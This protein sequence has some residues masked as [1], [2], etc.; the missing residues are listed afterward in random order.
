M[1]FAKTVSKATTSYG[2]SDW[3]VLKAKV[4]EFDASFVN[5]VEYAAVVGLKVVGYIVYAYN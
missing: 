3:I 1:V 4:Y 2:P 5:I